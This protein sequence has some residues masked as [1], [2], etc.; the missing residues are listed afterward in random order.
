[1]CAGFFLCPESAR[2]QMFT[3]L[4]PWLP[5]EGADYPYKRITLRQSKNAFAGEEAFWESLGMPRIIVT[6]FCALALAACG[7]G[8]GDT[9]M[10]DGTP[11]PV[12]APAPP[13]TS[14]DTVDTTCSKY[15]GEVLPAGVAFKGIAYAQSPEAALRWQP[16]QAIDCFETV[17]TAMAFGPAC[18]QLDDMGNVTSASEDC[19]YLNIWTPTAEFPAMEGRP[20][21]VFIHGG[22]NQRGSPDLEQLGVTLYDGAAL[23]AA[24]NVLVVTIGYRLGAL[25]FLSHP[26]LAAENTEG[27]SGNYGLLDQIAALQWLQSHI[28]A[29][30]G[31]PERVTI[32]GESGGARD[33]CSLVASPLANGLFAGAIM[34]SGGC[35]QRTIAEAENESLSITEAVG[36][37]SLADSSCLRDASVEQLLLA[38]GPELGGGVFVGRNI[39]PVV[40]GYVLEGSPEEVIRQ[41]AHNQVPL[42]IGANAQ[43]TG[44]SV[45]GGGGAIDA[46][47]YEALVRAQFGET[48]GALVLSRYPVEDY[49]SPAD[50]FIALS[51]DSQYICPARSVAQSAAAHSQSVYVYRFAKS[52]ES[53]VLANAGAFH[54]I[55]LFYV[56]QKVR[57]L[58]E[59]SASANDRAVEGEMAAYW[60]GFAATGDP[61][62][63]STNPVQWRPYDPALDFVFQVDGVTAEVAEPRA[64]QCDFWQG[65]RGG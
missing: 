61:N 42:I 21:L 13:L 55:E 9:P 64:A 27:L 26:A 59:Y 37:D 34:Q 19:L 49:S 30:G 25:G 54:G 53:T 7:G 6:S 10:M 52:F 38:L 47:A 58:A 4:N 23:S 35:R 1:M 2:Q 43:E 20:V 8:G 28:A 12:P 65:L 29:F 51:T 56:F 45:L 39:G 14:Q 48:L 16:P 40:D 15:Q 31:D 24:E 44:V 33:V 57:E 36:C 41:G 60:S 11:M 32:F 46:D 50:A 22:G 63:R 17:Q 3:Q 62:A 5:A 18:A